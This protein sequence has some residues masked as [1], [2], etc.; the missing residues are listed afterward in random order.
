MSAIGE[1]K[2][3]TYIRNMPVFDIQSLFA[4][5]YRFRMREIKQPG[6]IVIEHAVRGQEPHCQ[7]AFL[8]LAYRGNLFGDEHPLVTSPLQIYNHVLLCVHIIC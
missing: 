4:Q 8:V 5:I 6:V 2:Q 3:L 7:K 1:T